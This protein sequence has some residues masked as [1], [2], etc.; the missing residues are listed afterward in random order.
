MPST[1]QSII[2][3]APINQV[4]I[5]FSDFHDLSWAPSVITNVE[6][7]GSK[8][9]GEVGAKRIL[10]YVFH[11]TLIEFNADKYLLKYCIDDGPSPVSKEEVSNYI[12]V[13]KLSATPGNGGT[14]VEWSSSWESSTEEAV[15]FCH[16][17]YVSL[18]EE[19]AASFK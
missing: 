6:K 16:G 12:G 13:V 14:L 7:V 1:S 19:L 18:L 3:N 11:E 9:G 10:N 17:I 15:E 8:N 5:K 2:I 4:W